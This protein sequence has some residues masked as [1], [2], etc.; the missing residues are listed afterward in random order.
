MVN[1][2]AT[3]A[4]ANHTRSPQQVVHESSNGIEISIKHLSQLVQNDEKP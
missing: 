2:L 3:S 4:F 1:G